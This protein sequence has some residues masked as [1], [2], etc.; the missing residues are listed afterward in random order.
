MTETAGLE[1]SRV[2]TAEVFSMMST[3]GEEEGKAECGSFHPA[4]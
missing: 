2:L 4:L 1:Y 3:A